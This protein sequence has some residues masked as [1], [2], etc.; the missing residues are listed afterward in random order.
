VS[1]DE[2]CQTIVDL[3]PHLDGGYHSQ[4]ILGNGDRDVHLAA[5]ADVDDANLVA[6]K[7]GHFLDRLDG[8]GKAD[9]LRPRCAALDD[10]IFEARQ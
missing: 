7:T 4:L 10:E 3:A 9:P 5:V 6:Q 1:V 2:L 8:R